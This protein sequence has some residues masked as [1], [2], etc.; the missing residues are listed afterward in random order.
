MQIVF[1]ERI[2]ITLGIFS[3]HAAVRPSSQVFAYLSQVT[4]LSQSDNSFDKTQS[5]QD[6]AEDLSKF[7]LDSI[8]IA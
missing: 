6:M 8:F 2:L 7:I 3:T 1:S 4:R 5:H